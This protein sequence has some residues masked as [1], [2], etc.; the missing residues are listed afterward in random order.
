MKYHHSLWA[1]ARARFS[2]THCGRRRHHRHSR[3]RVRSH[4]CRCRQLPACFFFSSVLLALRI[5]PSFCSRYFV[6]LYYLKTLRAVIHFS[7]NSTATTWAKF[8]GSNLYIVSCRT[9]M[10]VCI[11]VCCLSRLLPHF[12]FQLLSSFSPLFFWHQF[13][14]AALSSCIILNT[15]RSYTTDI[16]GKQKRPQEHSCSLPL[17][18]CV[19]VQRKPKQ[20]FHRF[21]YAECIFVDKNIRFIHTQTGLYYKISL[22]VIFVIAVLI[23]EAIF[24]M[25][26]ERKKT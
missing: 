26:W 12:L 5:L 15:T 13:R 14:L 11:F 21:Y 4:R 23:V 24:Q 19:C 6:V 17:S 9:Y 2:C 8:Y 16:H 1:R 18:P 22:F 25:K 10:F 20:I 3:L 7:Q